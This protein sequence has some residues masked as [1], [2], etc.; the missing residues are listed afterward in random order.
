MVTA[1]NKAGAGMSITPDIFAERFGDRR[2]EKLPAT[3][4][5]FAFHL[6]ALVREIR[7]SRAEWRAFLS[8]LRD[9]GDYSDTRRDEWVLISDLFGISALVEEINDRRPAAAIPNTARG[10]F[11]RADTPDRPLGANICLDG[12]GEPLSVSGKVVDLDGLPIAGARV[13]TWQANGEGFYENQQPDR[14]PEF[15]L[16]GR[17]TTEATG[18]FHYRTVMPSGYP[19]PLVGPAGELLARAGF[20]PQRPAHLQFL[21]AAEG[22]ETITT[23][24]FDAEDPALVSDPLFA[25]RP[26]LVKSF[27]RTP[28][29]RELEVSFVMVRE[30]QEA[31]R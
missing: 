28:A 17:F 27:R 7:P 15:N 14:Q 10:P 1:R 29:G 4:I 3:L 22:F 19:V 16:R 2:S 31:L 9:I 11:Y 24:I 13:T 25:V 26:Q 23:H 6:Q 8:L 21:I 30:R 20:P 5:A 12:K 18:C